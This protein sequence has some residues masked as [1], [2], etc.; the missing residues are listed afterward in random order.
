VV[1][2]FILLAAA[3]ACTAP[4]LMRMA[5][6]WPL[7]NPSYS[8]DP[9]V[10]GPGDTVSLQVGPSFTTLTGKW[11]S[12]GESIKVTNGPE[13]GITDSDLKVTASHADWGG[14]I[15]VK[16][17]SSAD[18]TATPTASVTLPDMPQLAGKTIQFDIEMEVVYPKQSMSS[19]TDYSKDVKAHYS[20]T[21]SP[22]GSGSLYRSLWLAGLIGA[23]VL[24]MFVAGFTASSWSKRRAHQSEVWPLGENE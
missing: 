8:P 4:E 13:L 22:P 3:L 17:N 1:P 10:A 20:I 21:M 18:G 9:V 19:F 11:K 7:V 15:T 23:A 24:F 2:V 6:N 5:G 12:D 14:T 16:K